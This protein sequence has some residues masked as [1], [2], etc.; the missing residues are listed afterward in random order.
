M[1]ETSRREMLFSNVVMVPLGTH[2][3]ADQSLELSPGVKSSA[4]PGTGKGDTFTNLCPAFRQ[5]GRGQRAVL[6]S[7][8]HL[9]KVNLRAKQRI[10]IP[11][12]SKQEMTPQKEMYFQLR[13]YI[14]SDPFHPG[15]V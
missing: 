12:N 3:W 2:L 9:L 14:E 8:S 5:R 13:L 1:E 15:R 10:P 4:L 6:V 7:A 11:Y